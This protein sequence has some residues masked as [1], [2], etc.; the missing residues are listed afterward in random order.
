[1]SAARRDGG[2]RRRT[3]GSS[4]RLNQDPGK[5]SQ[6]PGRVASESETGVGR[7]FPYGQVR[8]PGR[9]CQAG[10]WVGARQTRAVGEPSHAAREWEREWNATAAEQLGA[11]IR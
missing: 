10:E 9:A 4:G 11:A 3:D 6:K 8:H 7:G 1:R 5:P 2:T